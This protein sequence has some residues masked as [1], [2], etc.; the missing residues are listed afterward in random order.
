MGKILSDSCVPKVNFFNCERLVP[1]KV[2]LQKGGTV[3]QQRMVSYA[4]LRQALRIGKQY[5]NVLEEYVVAS[6]RSNYSS[7]CY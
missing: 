3:F 6:F 4:M 7:E 5:A 1:S 2:Q